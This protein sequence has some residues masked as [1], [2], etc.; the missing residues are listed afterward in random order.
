MMGQ[1]V[2]LKGGRSDALEVEVCPE[3]IA[4]QWKLRFDISAYTFWSELSCGLSWTSC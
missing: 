3:P 1:T 2:C 4:L